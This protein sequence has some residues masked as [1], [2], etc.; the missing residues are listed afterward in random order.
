MPKGLLVVYS[1]PSAPQ[2]DSEYNDW[3]TGTHLPDML[4]LAGFTSARRYK[5]LEADDQPYLAMY[6]VEAD[7]LKAA[8]DLLMPAV[9]SGQVRMSDCLQLDPMPESGIYELIAEL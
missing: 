2:R 1:A 6:E 9:M 8:R 5:N 3:Y 4:S 7:D